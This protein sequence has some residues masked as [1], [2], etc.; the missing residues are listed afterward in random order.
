MITDVT[1][2][3]VAQRPEA[4]SQAYTHYC[5]AVCTAWRIA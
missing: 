4:L 1:E 3:I 5:P 2:K